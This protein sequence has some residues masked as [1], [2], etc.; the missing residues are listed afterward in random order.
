LDLTDEDK[1]WSAA[2]REYKFQIARSVEAAT[3]A[4]RGDRLLWTLIQ[5]GLATPQGERLILNDHS[6]QVCQFAAVGLSRVMRKVDSEKERLDNL[7]RQVKQ[8]EDTMYECDKA[9]TVC[10]V[11]NKGFD[12]LSLT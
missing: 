4:E 9:T 6:V 10:P 7:C 2:I 8:V 11:L 5:I 3:D 12:P 1:V